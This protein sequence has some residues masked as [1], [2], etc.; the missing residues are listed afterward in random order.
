MEA[1]EIQDVPRCRV[2]VWKTWLIVTAVYLPLAAIAAM[3]GQG[4]AARG[5]TVVSYVASTI[6]LFV[7]FG[8]GNAVAGVFSI[9]IDPFRGSPLRFLSLPAAILGMKYAEQYLRSR[10][11]PRWARVLGNLAVLFVVTCIVDFLISGAWLSMTIFLNHD[12]L[13]QCC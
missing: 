4:H 2:S 13:G 7:P 5:E 8:L 9:V 10:A 3:S 1:V 12:V 6:G 11:M